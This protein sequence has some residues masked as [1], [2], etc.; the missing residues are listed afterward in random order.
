M[1]FPVFDWGGSIATVRQPPN[2][3]LCVVVVVVCSSGD[4]GE[5]FLVLVSLYHSLGL[6]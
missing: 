4:M 3:A 1:C 2:P 5:G 6:C